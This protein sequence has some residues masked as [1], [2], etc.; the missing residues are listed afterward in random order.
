MKTAYGKRASCAVT[1][2][3]AGTPAA[4]ELTDSNCR[5]QDL[6]A[7]SRDRSPV[8]AYRMQVPRR[9]VLAAKMDG[10]GLSP[11][12]ELFDADW[13]S[14]TY[15]DASGESAAE[16]LASVEPGSYVLLASVSDA[17]MRGT[18]TLQASVEDPRTCS[19]EELAPGDSMAGELRED[20]CRVLDLQ[21]P[22]DDA[23]PLK[24]YKV[25]VARRGILSAEMTSKLFNP[26]VGITD[27][28]GK[29][30]VSNN[31]A[32]E[33]TA[34]SVATSVGPGTYFVFANTWDDDGWF[35]VGTAFE[36]PRA[37]EAREIKAGETAEGSLVSGGCRVMDAVAPSADANYGA[38]YTLNV[39]ERSLVS[40]EAA[41]LPD[42]ALYLFRAD[43]APVASAGAQFT[44]V[45]N[46][47]DYTLVA[48]DTQGRDGGFT[49]AVAAAAPPVCAVEEL[50]PG[51]AASGVLEA[52][53]CRIREVVAGATGASYTKSYR[54]DV[55]EAGTLRLEAA[56]RVLAAGLVFCNSDG[57]P[58]KV[59][60][61]AV[62][63][64]A[65]MRV[66]VA[67]GAYTV[68]VVSMSAGQTG[69]FELKSAFTADPAN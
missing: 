57:K 9:S 48:S 58:L 46:P 20:D 30:L 63:G 66:R 49:L 26:W 1:D 27:E 21:V 62:N 23:S 60:E 19:V 24:L 34:P 8:A 45:L 39:A 52:G 38:V 3:A 10:N 53:A 25:A 64:T 33:D 37:C 54:L 28:A 13:N 18:F 29:M 65:Q 15:T 2:I 32:E 16:V 22:S 14:I 7:P 4:G 43:S 68:H 47:G 6:L 35:R 36:D 61:A 59:A 50:A 69:A 17:A 42:P 41:N 51:A 12:L 67:P 40:A 31:D 55:P 56:S 5:Y 44:T 11:W